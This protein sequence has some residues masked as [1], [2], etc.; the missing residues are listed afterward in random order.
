M[1]GKY[2]Y[3]KKLTKKE[4]IS[5]ETIAGIRELKLFVEDKKVKMVIL[6]F[7]H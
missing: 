5:I 6:N 3:D 7:I 1:Y 2:V 4:E